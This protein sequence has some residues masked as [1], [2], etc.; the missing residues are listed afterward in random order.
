MHQH[1]FE[2]LPEHSR[3]H[4]ASGF[5]GDR[6]FIICGD[7]YAGKST[8]ALKLLYEGLHI[9]GDE[10]VLLRGSE[11]VTFPRKMYMR[12]DC[13]DLIPSFKRVAEDLPFVSNE[14]DYRIF[15]FDPLIIDRP[16]R[17]RPAKLG[18]VFYIEP[19]H[20]G[21]SRLRACGKLEMVQRIL[22]QAS[23]PIS[24]SWNWIG[25]ITAAV[26]QADSFIVD[27][28]DLDS[29]AID[30]KNCLRYSD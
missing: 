20:G 15:A 4:A 24:S 7:K 16:W 21:R 11:A 10:L 27:L 26:D 14:T 9:V 1:A 5:A 29:A 22:T 25:D 30:L 12:S 3:I 23:G 13:R 17:I 28:G 6:F 2:A 8:L 19:N 18:A